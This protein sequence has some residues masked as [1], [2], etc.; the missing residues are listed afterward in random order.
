[1]KRR[2]SCLHIETGAQSFCR[3]RFLPEVILGHYELGIHALLGVVAS[4]AFGELA[5]V[6]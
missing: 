2:R 1:M 4:A 5:G 6:V 3:V